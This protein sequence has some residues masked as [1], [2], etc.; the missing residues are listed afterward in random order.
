MWEHSK[1]TLASCLFALVVCETAFGQ[2][3]SPLPK[4]P[5]HSLSQDILASIGLPKP[6][7]TPIISNS[8]AQGLSVK[9]LYSGEKLKG[10]MILDV[11]LSKPD[12]TT[13]NQPSRK[14]SQ[15]TLYMDHVDPETDVILN[16]HE[17]TDDLVIEATLRDV[18]RNLI[19][20]TA[21]P[22]PVSSD[23]A[24]LLRLFPVE[25]P[26]IDADV[27]PDFTNIET[28]VGQ[29]NLP[30]K[31]P[32]PNGA[33]LHVQLLENALAGG[34]SMHLVAEHAEPLLLD[35]NSQSFTLQRG[36]WNRE[37][38]P[39]LSLKAWVSDSVGRKIFVMNKPVGY[40]GPDIDYKINLIGLKQGKDTKQGQRLNPQLM[41][42][43]LV[44]GEA[45]FDPVIG[46][47]GQ[48]R[49]NIKLKQD[50]GPYNQNPT[51]AEQ[52]LILR[53]METRIPF[54][55]TTDSTH[56]DPDAPAP[57]LSVSLT[58]SLGRIYYQSGD[59]RARDTNNSI[60]LYPH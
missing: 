12:R 24:R 30:R 34:L 8:E 14:I 29:V 31:T 32:F 17:G 60:R 7:L 43:T 5:P 57:F 37:D 19:L 40:N 47:P 38:T 36:L 39:N 11:I 25:I 33:T 10:A 20:R 28:I 21:N 56:F 52:T 54:T 51:L 1:S 16:F 3:V 4:K 27:I 9:L 48:A 46:I 53:G 59:V 6:Q 55:L 35:N 22:L 26:I 18:N 41:A 42:Q 58:D 15:S 49:L 45:I 13:A 44:Q 23:N 2:D 50:R